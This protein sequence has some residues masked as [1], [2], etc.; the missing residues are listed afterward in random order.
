MLKHISDSPCL[1]GPHSSGGV[2][3]GL[4]EVDIQQMCKIYNRKWQVVTVPWEE[5]K[6]EQGDR[7]GDIGAE[8]VREVK[9]VGGWKGR[10]GGEGRMTQ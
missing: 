2:G 1:L 9:G 4:G 8:S 3:R 7:A 10:Q 6:L 5:S